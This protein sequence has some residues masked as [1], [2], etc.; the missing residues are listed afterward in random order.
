MQ[1]LFKLQN[2]RSLHKNLDRLQ[3]VVNSLDSLPL[4]V[5]LTETWII[6]EYD[7][8]CLQLDGYLKTVTVSR[9]KKRSCYFFEKPN[10]VETVCK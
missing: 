1:K 10:R 7:T 3:I 4:A 9:G 6:E 8:A 5:W 2:I